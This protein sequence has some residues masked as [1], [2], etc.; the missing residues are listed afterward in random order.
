MGQLIKEGLIRGWGL[1]QV[2]ADSIAKAYNITSVSAIQNLYNIFE[3]DSEEKVLPYCLKNNIGFDL[4]PLLLV[5]YYL[6]KLPLKLNL[7][8]LMMLEIGCHN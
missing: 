5:V 2:E 7:K 4:F 1:S 3:R 6:E 8:K